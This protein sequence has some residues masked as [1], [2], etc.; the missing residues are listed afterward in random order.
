M[1]GMI[2]IIAGVLLSN[3]NS[4]MTLLLSMLLHI[5]GHFVVY[6]SN[7][8]SI[9][10]E[11]IV[12]Y[13]R[14]NS[15]F[16]SRHIVIDG[17]K[18][19]EGLCFSWANSYICYITNTMSKDNYQS[20][21]VMSVWYLSSIEPEV[22]KQ[23]ALGNTDNADG[24][25][26]DLYLSNRSNN[27]GFH[28]ISY[29]LMYEAYQWQQ[30]VIDNILK[31]YKDH[32]FN[33]CRVLISG[34]PGLGKSMIAK[35]IARQLKSA[36]CFELNLLEPGTRLL[37]LYRKTSP[38]RECPLIVQIDEFDVLI[39]NIHNQTNIRTCAWHSNQVL[40]KPSYNTFMSEYVTCLP[41]VIYICTSNMDID[42]FNAI[43]PSYTSSNRFDIKHQLATTQ[44]LAD[45]QSKAKLA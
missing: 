38:T 13:I 27:V 25:N 32:D 20:S 21:N 4:A 39:D 11:N 7:N 33:I 31:T 42:K 2:Y 5:Y 10:T 35:L 19:P 12:N 22:K 43:D 28:K 15:Y 14:E 40:D 30:D 34:K 9:N 3:I 41:N 17:K 16:I 6:D 1:I 37:N 23:Y 29:S 18:E 26:I 45:S 24:K 44:Q 8:D 36:C